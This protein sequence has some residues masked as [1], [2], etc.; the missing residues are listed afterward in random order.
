MVE[1]FG[2]CNNISQVYWLLNNLCEECLRK[3]IEMPR[4]EK[5]KR[6]LQRTLAK[7]AKKCQKISDTLKM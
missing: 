2:I 3:K 7:H 5:K 6:A 4:K 1:L